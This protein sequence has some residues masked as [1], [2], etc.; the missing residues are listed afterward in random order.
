MVRRLVLVVKTKKLSSLFLG[1][2][3]FFS[4]LC[5]ENFCKL[6]SYESFQ[7]FTAGILDRAGLEF[8]PES[9]EKGASFVFSTTGSGGSRNVSKKEVCRK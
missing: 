5:V 8:C 4:T 2:D 3:V 1:Y 9:S 6:N 7:A